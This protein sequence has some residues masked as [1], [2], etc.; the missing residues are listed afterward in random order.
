MRSPIPFLIPCLNLAALLW[1]GPLQA[2]DQTVARQLEALG[3]KITFQQGDVIQVG[4]T[5]C[6]KLGPE[7]FK[8][9]GALAHLKTLTLYGRCAGLTDTTL[10]LLSGL[11]ELETFGVDGAQITDA[12]LEQFVAFTNLKALSFFH[13]SFR[14]P[15]FTGVG[16]GHLKGCPKLERL[17]VAGMS[18]GDEAFAAIAAITQLKDLSTWHTFQTEAGNHE[19]AKLPNL[20]KLSLGQRLPRSGNKTPSLSDASIP[21]LLG[22]KSLET[23][24][25]GEAHFTLEGLRPLKT[26]PNLKRL[27]LYET[28]LPPADVEKLSAEFASINVEFAPLTENQRKKLEMYLRQ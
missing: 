16:L 7:E 24:R 3:A 19:I 18:I 27:A 6:S 28:D 4:L 1:A 25:I 26:L 11:K 10:P 21:A 20:Q 9:I 15:G 14:M 5:D 17:T 13:L 12:A 23:L 22:M 2:D 8:A